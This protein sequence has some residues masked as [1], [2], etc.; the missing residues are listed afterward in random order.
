MLPDSDMNF[1]FTTNNIKLTSSRVFT[2]ITVSKKYQEILQESERDGSCLITC[3]HIYTGIKLTLLFQKEENIK[4]TYFIRYARRVVGFRSL[5]RV[6]RYFLKQSGILTDNNHNMII[7]LSLI[8]YLQV[9]L[10]GKTENLLLSD[11]FTG[12]LD[13]ISQGSILLSPS[14]QKGFTFYRYAKSVESKLDVHLDFESKESERIFKRIIKLCESSSTV[15]RQFSSMREYKGN[16]AGHLFSNYPRIT[17]A[18]QSSSF[19]SSLEKNEKGSVKRV[20]KR[21]INP[22]DN[23]KVIQL[24]VVLI[25]FTMLFIVVILFLKYRESLKKP[26]IPQILLGDFIESRETFV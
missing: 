12:F 24:L 14:N 17:Q 20:K 1:C 7:Y 4:F 2:A 6:F 23:L 5:Y 10:G 13:Q 26:A 16:I 9:H 19:Y 21:Q 15:L 25:V 11:L 22:E 8:F 18:M 3:Q